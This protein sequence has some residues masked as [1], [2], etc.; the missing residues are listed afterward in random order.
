MALLP[1]RIRYE[2]LALLFAFGH[3]L[4]WHR[5]GGGSQ[6]QDEEE[7]KGDQVKLMHCDTSGV[8]N[9]G[10]LRDGRGCC[11]AFYISC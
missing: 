7:G 3:R 1:I 6:R 4:F 10:Q 5:G 2:A 8:E 9:S 11:A